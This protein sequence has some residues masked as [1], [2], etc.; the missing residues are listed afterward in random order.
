ME[1]DKWASFI[2]GGILTWKLMLDSTWQ[3]NWALLTGLTACLVFLAASFG[4]YIC[5]RMVRKAYPVSYRW[6]LLGWFIAVPVMALIIYSVLGAIYSHFV[7]ATPETTVSMPA[8]PTPWTAITQVT[9]QPTTAEIVSKYSGYTHSASTE[10]TYDQSS[11]ADFYYGEQPLYLLGNGEAVTLTR[12]DKATNPTWAQ[13]KAFMAQDQTDKIKYSQGSFVC[14]NYAE[15]VYN[16]AEARGIRAAFVTIQFQNGG[17]PH[18]LNAFQTTDRGL[19]YIDSTGVEKTSIKITKVDF[20]DLG[21]TADYDRVGY[22]QVGKPYGVISLN[23]NYGIAYSSYLNWQRDMNNFDTKLE[24]YNARVAEYNARVEAFNK[25][26]SLTKTY[27]EY[28]ALN[29]ERNRLDLRSSELESDAKKLG[30]FWLPP[31]D[32]VPISSIEI[33]W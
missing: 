10:G 31:N 32:D 23:T 26:S 7:P 3:Y 5:A 9:A 13:V 14:S 20:K 6:G 27:G 22:I 15:Q 18:A 33:Y 16:N 2:W 12:N 30:G 25:E 19:I 24:Q 21:V 11:G 1:N 8:A 4:F 28:Q 29:D 17:V